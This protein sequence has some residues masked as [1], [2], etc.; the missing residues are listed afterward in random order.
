[1][2]EKENIRKDRSTEA[3]EA[4]KK[5]FKE[6]MMRIRAR[7]LMG[8]MLVVGKEKKEKEEEEGKVDKEIEVVKKV[9][10][11]PDEEKEESTESKFQ[12]LNETSE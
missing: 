2:L 9:H 1:M 10:E 6:K 4:N 8:K 11:D 7:K 5:L 12:S 3:E